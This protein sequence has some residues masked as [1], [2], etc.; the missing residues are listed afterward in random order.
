MSLGM[1]AF[2]G[3]LSHRKLASTRNSAPAVQKTPFP[4]RVSKW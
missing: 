3:T 1:A 2:T 4:R